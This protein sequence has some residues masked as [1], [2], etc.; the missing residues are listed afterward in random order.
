MGL[1]INYEE[2]LEGPAAAASFAQAMAAL[3]SALKAW[4]TSL[5]ITIAPYYEVWQPYRQLLQV[6]CGG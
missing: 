5:L 3:I 1:D 6:G 4:R 2:G